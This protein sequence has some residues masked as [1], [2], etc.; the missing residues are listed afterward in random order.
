MIS[1]DGLSNRGR[2][3]NSVLTGA[4]IMWVTPAC[5]RT[6]SDPRC[7]ARLGRQNGTEP[8]T[9]PITEPECI[10]FIRKH[11]RGKDERDG[12]GMARNGNKTDG[13]SAFV[14]ASPKYLPGPV[15]SRRTMILVC[16]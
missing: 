7:R 9:E 3:N 8:I 6:R 12:E 14:A 4:R 1:Q 11:A 2:D 5:A 15:Q 16:S 10:I 13:S